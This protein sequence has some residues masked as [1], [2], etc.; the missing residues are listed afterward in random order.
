MAKTS[1]LRKF[2]KRFAL[3]FLI[4]LVLLIGSLVAIPF[5][6]R[7]SILDAVRQAAN[8]NLHATV[9]FEDASI[10]LLRQFPLLTL[11]LDEYEVVGKGDFLG[12]PLVKGTSITFSVD[13]RSIFRENSPLEIRQ[14]HLDKPE[15]NILVLRDGRANYDI[16]LPSEQ[17]DLVVESEPIDFKIQLDAYSIQEGLLKYTDRSLETRVLA[18]GLNHEGKG[19]FTSN[20]YQLETET[21]IEA[22]SVS[23][24]GIPY[25]KK[26]KTNLSAGFDIDLSQMKFTLL[27]NRLLIN[28]LPLEFDGFVALPSDEIQLD[29]SFRSPGADFKQLLSMIPNAYIEGYEDVRAEG[30]FSLSGKVQ[31]IY[32]DTEYPAFQLQA[33]VENASVKYPDLP[34]GIS[35][36]QTNIAVVSQ[37]GS[38]DQMRIDI[39]TFRMQVGSN[40]ISGRLRLLTPI[41]DPD[42]DAEVKGRLDLGEFAQAYPL[43]DIRELSGLVIADIELRSTLSQLDLGDYDQVQVAGNFD[44]RQVVYRTDELP[45]ITI[46]TMNMSF[47]PQ[48]VLVPNFNLQL[49]KSD[50]S[51]SARFDNILAY[52]SPTK[53]LT[54]DLVL[55]SNYFLADE[56]TEE[57]TEEPAPAV[58]AAAEEE[59]EFNRFAFA[60]DADFKKI[61]YDVYT[62]L[63][64]RVIGDFS[65]N[66]LQAERFQTQIGD[67]DFLV[68]GLILNA[69][70]YLYGEAILKGIIELRSS[71]LNLNQFMAEDASSPE[72]S[73]ETED[74]E[75]F[76][77]PANVDL[78]ID[79]DIDRVVYTNMDMRQLRGRVEIFEEQVAMVDC[80]S[81]TLGGQIGFSGTYDTQ[82]LA[83]PAFGMKLDL[84]NLLFEETF[85]TFNSFQALAPIGKYI[86]GRLNSTLVME[87]ILGNDLMPDLNTITIDGFLETFNAILSGY[88]PLQSVGQKLNTDAFN[89]MAIQNTRNWFTIANGKVEV[90]EFDYNYQDIAMKIGGSH[91]L[92][93]EMDYQ[94][95]AKVPR[96]LIGDNPVGAAAES[97][98]DML[99]KEASNLGVDIEKSPF[100]NLQINLRGN[101]K[102]PKVGIKLLGT[103][104]E[105]SVT[106]ALK[107]QARDEVDEQLDRVRSEVDDRVQQG[108]EQ[109]EDAAKR[110]RDS[111]ENLATKKADEARQRALERMQA[112]KDAAAKK[113]AEELEKQLGKDKVDDIKGKLEDYNP[114]KKKKKDNN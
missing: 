92:D 31:G 10:S 6:F 68:S 49:G 111:L 70:D 5:F 25:L 95:L 53:I 35:N 30:R 43:P 66:R 54:G 39:P 3:V 96:E 19:F 24:E 38:L 50:L 69:W 56:W 17:P 99:R 58:S 80:T 114:L 36:I 75:P 1:N 109:A 90:Q 64:T 20:Q 12:V 48:Q 84:S 14:V 113:A 2:I 23:Y 7:D 40:P 82:D 93:Q 18:T 16:T 32:S 83:K 94:I 42:I 4:L 78:E 104:G 11:Q 81:Q 106:E 21:G 63:D 37:Q 74:Y 55:K 110:I 76:P 33:N 41:S 91:G 98:L 101:I 65:P 28:E 13:V 57:T 107:D 22:L 46:K 100:V 9:D 71:Y 61:D 27:D 77:V 86:K 59:T 105:A 103:D 29:L 102:D 26:A 60:L 45:L 108:K 52:F 34:L 8:D 44:M 73:G 87:G 62:L 51:G 79:A 97:G 47:T 15:L 112:E 89:N 88:A 85:Q 72:S 67:S